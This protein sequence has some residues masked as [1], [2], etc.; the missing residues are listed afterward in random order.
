MVADPGQRVLRQPLVVVMERGQI[1]DDW[2]SAQRSYPLDK[3]EVELVAAQAA[4]TPSATAVECE[5]HTLSCAELDMRSNQLANHLRTRGVA[6]QVLVGVCLPRS[7][8]MLV[9]LLDVFRTGAA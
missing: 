8:Q 4:A 3:T 7:A 6:T 1:A 9:S 5:R 2:N